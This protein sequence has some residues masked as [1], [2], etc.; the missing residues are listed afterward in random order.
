MKR[1][2]FGITLAAGVLLAG[3]F[4]A[5]Y[6]HQ[7]VKAQVLSQFNESQLLIAQQAAGHIES[8]FDARSQDV[9]YLSSLTSLQHLDAKT[10]P[11]D[12][13]ATFTRLKTAYVKNI[14]VL[15]ATGQVVY[16][17]AG[18]ASGSNN[19][20]PDIDA[21]AKKP[22]NK[23]TVRLVVEKSTTPVAST[24][25]DG[26]RPPSRRLFLVTPLYQEPRVGGVPGAGGTFAGMVL[27]TIDLEMLVER[28]LGFTPT[29]L[30][31]LRIWAMDEDGT[32]L[33]Q[34]EHPEMVLNNIRRTSEVCHQC[35]TSFDY[36]EKML[37]AKQ[38]TVEYQLKGR[39]SKVAA[40]AP[41]T[42]EGV[43]W[44]VVVNAPRDEITGFIRTNALETVGLFGV[45]GMVVGVAFLSVARNFRQEIVI[46]ETAKHLQEKERLV[47]KLG[48]ALKAAEAA[49]A[50]KSQFL[51]CMSHEL[52]TP[53]NAVIGMTQLL[54]DTPLSAQQAEFAQMSHMGGE[55][56]LTLINNVLDFSKLE[57]GKMDLEFSGFDLLRTVEDC[58]RLVAVEAHEK[59]LELVVGVESDTPK[60][61]RGD[62]GRLRQVLGNLLNNAI[63]FTQSGEVVLSARKTAATEKTVTIRFEVRDTGVGVPPEVQPRLFQAFS[64]ADASTTRRYGGT[65]LGLA[66]SRWIVELMGGRIGLESSEGRGAT[67]WFEIP[68][69]VGDGAETDRLVGAD[70]AAL[71]I[72]VVDDSATNREIL[73]RRL[74]AWGMRSFSEADGAGALAE[75][76]RAAAV[77]QAYD[78]ALIDMQMPGMDGL[79]LARAIRAHAAL[80]RLPLI[81]MTS[82]DRAGLSQEARDEGVESCLTKPVR[83]SS[84]FDAIVKAVSKNA[85]ASGE[86]TA[87]GAAT[88][89][90]KK[91]RI[92]IAEDNRVNQMVAAFMLKKLGYESDVVDNG[93][94][95][96]RAMQSTPYALILMDLHMPEMDGFGATAAIRGKD[97][98]FK[99]IP[100]IAV[101]A[102]ALT[103]DREKCAQA[104]MSDYLSKPLSL[105][106][107]KRVL[108]DWLH[109]D[110]DA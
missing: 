20:G 70:L 107:L 94:E 36:A 8:Y 44:I 17:T 2:L 93:V 58:A 98:K 96:L 65:G 24:T 102:D 61:L 97:G 86:D 87:P 35:H 22:V 72:L 74:D 38:G 78:L 47:E 9:R 34:S 13:Q 10:M 95:A 105:E 66:I 28:A 73:K 54:L 103:G 89:A 45:V 109:E 39:P 25:G 59:G 14:V 71:R 80:S 19:A 75:L 5:F 16:S 56:L 53:L 106:A 51:A 60:A 82:M 26:F 91:G 37:T 108:S 79:D 64:Q 6:L 23:G 50:A 76:G 57:A 18:D 77:R 83:Q 15:D 85:H 62:D 99:D 27:L 101:T 7:D 81:L 32:L 63:K 40:F 12:V 68:F 31:P 55:T 110:A 92:L 11:A 49:A 100:I 30:H 104:G 48:V 52:R 46:A 21:W 42:V 43:S 67:F 41:M 69:E 4:L 84:L 29:S 88:A 90:A 3:A 33:L 1:H